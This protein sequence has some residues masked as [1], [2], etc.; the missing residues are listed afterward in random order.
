MLKT[1]GIKDLEDYTGLPR[2]TIHFYVKEGLI[3]PPEGAG[4]G[5]Y[6]GLDHAEALLLITALKGSTHLRLEGIRE[7]LGRMSPD[8]RHT[9]SSQILRGERT[10]AELAASHA[11]GT[12]PGAHEV[13]AS[14]LPPETDRLAMLREDSVSGL[15]VMKRLS[16]ASDL[17]PGELE[18]P[19]KSTVA[20]LAGRRSLFG[21]LMRKQPSRTARPE[22]WERVRLADD[23]EIHFRDSGDASRRERIEAIVQMARE[24]IEE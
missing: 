1:F 6:Y 23:L 7:I 24:M 11:M 2:R 22:T 8:E 18:V 20:P 10:A 21:R 19:Q 12:A 17:E 9:W 13:A 15:D 14:S 4:R 16:A 3:P 5:A